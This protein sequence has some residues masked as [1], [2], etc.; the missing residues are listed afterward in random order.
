MLGCDRLA[1]DAR[2]ALELRGEGRV[3]AMVPLQHLERD[4]AAERLLTAL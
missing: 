3:G 2:L 1:E 4:G